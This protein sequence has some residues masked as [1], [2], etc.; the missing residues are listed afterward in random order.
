MARAVKLSLREVKS[1]AFVTSPHPPCVSRSLAPSLSTSPPHT[2]VYVCCELELR[3]RACPFSRAA[4]NSNRLG[5]QGQRACGRAS[6]LC[7]LVFLRFLLKKKGVKKNATVRFSCYFFSF[8]S[9]V[10]LSQ[11][12]PLPHQHTLRAASVLTVYSQNNRNAH[13]GSHSSTCLYLSLGAVLHCELV[14]INTWQGTL[15]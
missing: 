10:L 1:N 12:V 2:C 4:S 6:G 8:S 11:L 9:A 15:Y 7:A 3:V 5:E 13:Y 14:F